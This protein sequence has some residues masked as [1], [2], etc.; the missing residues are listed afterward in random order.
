MKYITNTVAKISR[1]E[2]GSGRMMRLVRIFCASK[3]MSDSVTRET[4]AVPLSTSME[5]LPYG[6]SMATTACGRITWRSR[7]HGDML[8]ATV[9][10][11]CP[12]SIDWMPPRTTSEPYAPMFRP[13][14]DHPRLHR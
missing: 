5:R 14:G 11:V 9:A 1:V 12:A 13:Q 8:R 10:S 2:G 7:C 3:V 4:S 6:G